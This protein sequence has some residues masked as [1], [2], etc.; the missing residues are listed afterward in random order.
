MSTRYTRNKTLAAAL[1]ALGGAAGLHRFYL[2]GWRDLGG[3]LLT[4]PSALGVWGVVRVRTLGQDDVLSWW[5]MPPLGVTLTLG[6][7]MAVI[8]ALTPTERWNQRHNPEGPP[9]APAGR[10]H[11][12]TVTVLVFALMA[13]AI[14]F[15][16]TLAFSVQRYFESQVTTSA[17]PSS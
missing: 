10:S 1:A 17:A 9:D 5:L 15:M 8:Y 16:S 13:G 2:Y 4:L 11:G 12:L 7:L 3:W 14:A 6:C